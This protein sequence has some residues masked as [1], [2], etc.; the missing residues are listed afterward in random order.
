MGY[1]YF[2]I[3]YEHWFV[4]LIKHETEW[5]LELLFPASSWTS[6]DINEVLHIHV[7][8]LIRLKQSDISYYSRSMVIVL[9]SSRPKIRRHLVWV[10]DS[11][12]MKNGVFWVVTPCGSYKSHTA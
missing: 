5:L 3:F 8:T 7:Q 2:I 4:I 6:W 12:I 9:F 1:F 11:W 10:K